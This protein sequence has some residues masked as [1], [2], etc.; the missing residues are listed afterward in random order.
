[1]TPLSVFFFIIAKYDDPYTQKQRVQNKFLLGVRKMALL[2]DN[3]WLKF[4]YCA[5]RS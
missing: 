3:S 4:V 2:E 5:V 1:M